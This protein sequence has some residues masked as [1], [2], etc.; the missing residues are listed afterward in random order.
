MILIYWACGLVYSPYKRLMEQYNL[1]L[2]ILTLWTDYIKQFIP[3][4]IGETLEVVV[5]LLFNHPSL[6]CNY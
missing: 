4:A 1:R 5:D 3:F 2:L 6:Y